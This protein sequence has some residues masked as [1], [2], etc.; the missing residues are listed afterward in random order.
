MIL[1]A[2]PG[3]GKSAIA[4]RLTQTRDDILAYHFCTAG[5]SATVVPNRVFRALAAQLIE[6]L[7]GYGEALANTID[8]YRT[9]IKVNI[10]VERMLGGSVVGV[11]I[12]NLVASDPQEV[13]DILLRAP[14]QELTPPAKPCF[15]LID[16]LDEAATFTGGETLPRLLSKVGDPPSW[17]RF[18]CTSR[19]ERP[20]LRYFDE[21]D[22]YI[23]DAES[24]ENLRDTELYVTRRAAGPQLADRLGAAEVEPET[25]TRRVAD[26]AR[27]NFLYTQVLLDDIEAGRQPLDDLAALPQSLDGIYHQ[28]LARF[29]FDEWRDRYQPLFGVLAVARQPI[30][31]AHL[32]QFTGI[33]AT[34]LNQDLGVV[35]QF[36]TEGHDTEG[37][38]TYTLFHQSIRDYLLDKKRS[39]D[40]WC[41]PQE[42][43]ARIADYY[44]N[45][46]G[47]LEAGLP[48]LGEQEKRDLD[49][50]YGL[51]H[52]VAHLER[53]NRAEDV[54]HMLLLERQVGEHWVNIWYAAKEATGD[55]G[56]Y[57]TD[58]KHAWALA[59]EAFVRNRSPFDIGLQ[60]RY[61]LINASLNSLA[62]NIPPTMPAALVKREIWTPIQGVVYAQQMSDDKQRAEALT[63]LVPHLPSSLKGEALRAGL[64][65]AW[66]IWDETA[67]TEAL[68]RLDSYLPELLK[69]DT[70]QA[71]L[72]AARM[73]EK[74][75][76]R[77]KALMSLAPH[78]TGTLRC[79]VLP[80]ALADAQEITDEVDQSGALIGLA[81]YLPGFL[82]DEQLHQTVQTMVTAVLAISWEEDQAR[83]LVELVPQ[84]QTL[85]EGDQLQYMLQSL[86]V[87]AQAIKREGVRLKALTGLVAN[88]PEPLKG[89]ALR[90]A[91]TAVREL[92]EEQGLSGNPRAEALNELVPHISEPF[93]REALV[94]ARSIESEWWQLKVLVRLAPYLPEVL[95]REVLTAVLAVENEWAREEALV[96]LAPHLSETLQAHT[97]AAVREFGEPDR[98]TNVL[99]ALAPHLPEALLLD[100]LGM[101][102]E[103]WIDS[104]RAKAFSNLALYLAEPLKSD[105]LDTALAM[106][107]ELESE[108]WR[109][110]VFIDLIPS[111]WEPLRGETSRHA[112]AA[113]QAMRKKDSQA[114]EM[115]ALALRLTAHLPEVEQEQILREAL[116]AIPVLWDDE[117]KMEALVKLVPHLPEALLLEALAIAIVR[118]AGW[119][120]SYMKRDALALLIP[121]LPEALLEEALE[122][123]S[124]YNPTW[125]LTQMA[126]RLPKTMLRE[127][128][129][130]TR[131]IQDEGDQIETLAVLAPYLPEP[132]REQALQEVLAASWAI[133]P[134][135]DRTR[136]LT[137]LIPH[138]TE[139]ILHETLTAAREIEDKAYRAK[140]LVS[141][142]PYL[143]TLEREEVLRE[144]V[145]LARQI[146]GHDREEVLSGLAPYL[147]EPL[148]REALIVARAELR[149]PL[150]FPHTQVRMLVSLATQLPEP[151]RSEILQEGLAIAQKARPNR[152]RKRALEELAPYLSAQLQREALAAAREIGDENTRA[153]VLSELAP[154]LPDQLLRQALTLVL[155][156]KDAERRAMT[157][158][159]IAQHLSEELLREA[160]DSAQATKDRFALSVLTL[161]LAELGQPEEALAIEPKVVQ[162]WPRIGAGKW[163][164]EKRPC[165][166]PE[167]LRGE[168][169]QA[170]M[171]AAR[172]MFKDKAEDLYAR[173]LTGLALQL[174]EPERESALKEALEIARGIDWS[175]SFAEG[176]AEELA[177][178]VPHLAQFSFD[179][180]CLLW[181]ETF[182]VL[183]SRTRKD[184]LFDLCVLVPIIVRLGGAEAV[185]EIYH[186]IQDVGR[187]WP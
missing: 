86:L 121:R 29:T 65:A 95:L 90:E 72:A 87:A 147:S 96:G 9:E 134:N 100:A 71:A 12:E 168:V 166:L 117:A 151:S 52:L 10:R 89:E 120:L 163:G 32:E 41:G 25:F 185:T 6:N 63:E 50:G 145:A 7:P 48:E 59:E 159:E 137:G 11:Y 43:H 51:H 172:D 108:W 39:Q 161:Q 27:G 102:Q 74:G 186:A 182:P 45:A 142:V 174:P 171:A 187:W 114:K 122:I 184:L 34:V 37:N 5:D 2:N 49:G 152:E 181:N 179:T 66:K 132:D 118:T 158:F 44:L 154:H 92:P 126:P 57:L 67:S 133:E 180:L 177:A 138:L 150:V 167:P 69:D 3:V 14:L 116:A 81:P 127:A 183:A 165:H 91:L 88:L 8:P 73:I 47:G 77:V 31:Q 24:E 105:A 136:V 60:C 178:L 33:S 139:P 128:L 35:Q 20:V 78:L 62:Q 13:L 22:P 18:L 143:P 109:A 124:S 112:L 58:A 153:E 68:A 80:Q 55:T 169:L 28:F 155:E 175:G 140:M 115:I 75:K 16:S 119:E 76:R 46:W 56:G 82:Q 157:L 19:P 17:V 129:A 135:Y 125:A 4:A 103:I 23:L 149:G 84:L 1:V 97:L 104:Y 107:S 101:A 61:A 170:A 176:R 38:T 162:L 83:A 36:L 21:L 99:V 40:F 156:I 42:G 53:A 64:L 93:L 146:E 148:L 79:E 111:L 85:L 131:A 144:G 160:L 98:R 26:L 141:L 30:T 70:L 106:T 173:T 54:H 94:V 130:T 164:L 15:I 110:E 113:V 123:G